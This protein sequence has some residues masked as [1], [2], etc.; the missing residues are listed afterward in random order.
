MTLVVR[1]NGDT[2]TLTPAIKRTVE[3]LGTRAVYDI[4]PFD[5]YVADSMDD[6]RFSMLLLVV[7]ATVSLLLAAIGL[8]GTLAYLTSRRT[9]EFG[10]RMALGASGREIVALVAREGALLTG[11]GGALGILGALAVGRALS[12]LLYNVAPI[13]SLTLAAVAGLVAIVALGAMSHPAWRAACVDPNAVI[14]AP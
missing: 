13:D 1:T 7:F 5:T 8:Y 10:I 9:Q 2:T 6:T 11:V 12:H 14:N 4:R 3:G